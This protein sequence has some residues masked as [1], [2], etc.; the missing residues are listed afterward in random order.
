M[1]TAATAWSLQHRE[2]PALH[3]HL[4][5]PT[6]IDAAVTL[7]ERI[8]AEIVQRTDRY[9][10]LLLCEHPNGVT[11]GRDGSA[12]D[13]HLDREELQSRG[14]PVRWLR[15]GG[16]TW[17]HHPGQI[18]AYLVAPLDRLGL[19]VPQFQE[20]LRQSLIDLGR[21][22]KLLLAPEDDSAGLAARC[23]TVGF[24]GAGVNEQ[25]SQ[26]GG[27]LNVSVPRAA[28]NVVS[29]GND[30]RPSSVAAERMRPTTMAAL[31]ESWIRHLAVRCGYDRYHV[32]TGHPAMRRTTRRMYVVT[33]SEHS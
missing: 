5:G 18:V 22:Q 27:C 28:L 12:A 24:I 19:T 11:I 30:V 7:Q 15:R 16:G 13:L 33:H 14:I 4:L 17:V 21:E 6:E 20:S 29:W 32:W 2:S 25:V 31:R 1:R 8:S 10:V 23:G 26:F 9:G 3:V